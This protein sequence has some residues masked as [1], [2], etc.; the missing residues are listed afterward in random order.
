MEIQKPVDASEIRATGSLQVARDE[1]IRLRTTLGHLAKD[2]GFAD[3]VYDASDLCLGD[4]E[5]QDF[6]RCVEEI[7]YIR[8]ALQLSTQSSKRRARGP[9]AQQDMCGDDKD[10]DDDSGS[11]DSDDE[12]RGAGRK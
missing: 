4:D 8:R 7:S 9:Y 1:I 10:G 6:E 3:V 11:E 12:E 2:A 5:R